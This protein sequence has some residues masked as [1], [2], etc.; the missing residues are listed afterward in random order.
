MATQNTNLALASYIRTPETLERFTDL[1]GAN[2]RAY[3]QSV[4]IAAGSTDDLMKCTPQSIVRSA[5]RAASLGLSCDPAL[6]QAW[7]VPYNKNVGT[8]DNPQWVKEAQFQPHYKGLHTLAMRTGKYVI[9]NVSPVYKGQRVMEDPLTGLHAVQDGNALGQPAAYNSAYTIDVTLR[10]S[11][12]N[13]RIGWLGYFKTT[14]GFQKSV[15]MSSIEIDDHA[16]KYVKDYEKNPNWNDSEKRAVMEMKTVLKQLLSWADL[17]GVENLK[18]AEALQADTEEPIEGVVDDLP[19]QDAPEDAPAAMS[20]E[21]AVLVPIKISRG[22]K[23]MSDLVAEELN[24]VYLSEKT[25]QEQKDAAAI[26]LKHDFNMDTPEA[27]K[28]TAEKNLK[29]LGF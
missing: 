14:K 6:K 7:L 11:K 13:E 1:L 26:I 29:E 20:Y 21:Y 15:W 16:R 19:K 25:S 18:L 23:M 2:S 12:E 17:S 27:E 3:I 4:I 22:E 24:K 28:K 9:I 5:L 8:R 10:R